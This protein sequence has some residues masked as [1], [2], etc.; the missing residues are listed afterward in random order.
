MDCSRYRQSLHGYVSGSLNELEKQAVSRH[1]E[2][3]EKCRSEA[4]EISLLR[5][6]FAESAA[7]APAPAEDLK[8]SIM[9]S[10]D[11]NRYKPVRK[12]KRWEMTNWG[13]S[14]VAAGLI[15]LLVN[16]SP[17]GGSVIE[18]NMNLLKVGESISERLSQ[19]IST[20]NS[21]LNGITN[22]IIQLDGIS[23]RL[24][25]EKKGGK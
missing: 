11:L 1:L 22:K 9:A 3:C 6:F 10:I 4:D 14:L 13:I 12:V 15:L 7:K 18:S 20:I 25:K 2:K 8:L 24:E 23:G 16:I 19:P 21:G 17:N 5:R